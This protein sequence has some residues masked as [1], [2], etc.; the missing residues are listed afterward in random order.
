MLGAIKITCYFEVL[1][2]IRIKASKMKKCWL[3][4]K[5]SAVIEATRA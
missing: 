5:L 3:I 1:L 2:S 4:V